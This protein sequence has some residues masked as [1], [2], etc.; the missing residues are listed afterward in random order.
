MIASQEKAIANSEELI[1]LRDFITEKFGIYFDDEKLWLLESKISRLMQKKSIKSI[2]EYYNYLIQR[3]YLSNTN[4]DPDLIEL[5][6]ILS[7]NE[8]YFYREADA[9]LIICKEIIPNLYSKQSNLRI[10]CAGCSSGEEVY[11]LAISLA[12]CNS[13]FINSAIS[14][15]GIDIDP[16]AIKMAS[17]GVYKAS[18]FRGIQNNDLMENLKTYFDVIKNENEEIF[19][20]KSK[21]KNV[22]SFQQVNLLD[23]MSILRLG[24]FDAILCR[25]VLIYFN[26]EGKK[27][28]IRNFSDLLNENGFLFLG[29]AETIVGKDQ[30]FVPLETQNLIYYK[31]S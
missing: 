1:L 11:S 18:A 2:I 8:T 4:V 23:R 30:Y 12:E 17:A 13:L 24:K 20:V 16:D 3:F 26:D 5:I 27:T 6:K 7:N 15:V 25:N 10:L 29:H 31:K 9:F 22:I 28:V 14:I 19:I 21:I